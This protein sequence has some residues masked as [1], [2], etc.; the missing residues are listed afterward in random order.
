MVKTGDLNDINLLICSVHSA[1]LTLSI[2]LSPT[3]MMAKC[4]TKM[5]EHMHSL[6]E[7]V[8]YQTKQQWYYLEGFSL[9]LV[10]VLHSPRTK[11]EG[12]VLFDSVIHWLLSCFGAFR[13]RNTKNAFKTTQHNKRVICAQLHY[14]SKWKEYTKNAQCTHTHSNMMIY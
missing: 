1:S 5:I 14:Y 12:N 7:C 9:V 2:S 4:V 13:C 8:N 10:L 3:R 11:T 6:T